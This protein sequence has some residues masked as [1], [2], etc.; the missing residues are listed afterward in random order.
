VIEWI[1]A[2]LLV[3]PVDMD[4]QTDDVAEDIGDEL[5]NQNA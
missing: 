4:N 2:T 1:A 5:D 3:N